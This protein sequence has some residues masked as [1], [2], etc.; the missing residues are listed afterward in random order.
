MRMAVMTLELFLIGIGTGNPD[1]VTHQAVKAMR[2][3]EVILVPRKGTAKSD[4]ADLRHTICDAVLGETRP[5]LVEFDLPVRDGEK[6]Y[7][8]AVD[9]WHDAIALV[10]QDTLD[11]QADLLGHAPRSAALLIWGDPSLY[12]SSLRIA[13][14]LSPE[15]HITVIPG[16]TSVQALTAA[17]AI[18]VNE[19]G[20]P[21]IVTT[22]RR[23]RD[24]GFPN[25]TDTAI[26]M[27]DGQCSFTHLNMSDFD[28]WWGAYLGMDVEII[29]AGKL[30]AVADEIIQMRKDARK[31][32][33]W[34]M[35]CYLLKRHSR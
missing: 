12:D 13:A 33:G 31:Q 16:I 7:L 2:D 1:H 4:L 17:H 24:E 19:L 6:T 5:A 34:I 32:Q 25:D 9:E 26:I 15:P 28:I 23:L 22:G 3:V 10:W 27:L 29:K 35:D 8:D 30:D 14:R 20:A 11:A 21:F 18:P